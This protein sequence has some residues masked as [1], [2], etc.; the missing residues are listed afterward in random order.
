M[1]LTAEDAG[2]RHIVAVGE[3]VRVRLRETPTTGYLWRPEVDGEALELLGDSVDVADVPRGAPGW[4]VFRFRVRRGGPTA[5][6]LVQG[7]AWESSSTAEYRVD[8]DAEG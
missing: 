3:E 4:H 8:L 2:S 7:R 6:T 1:D 5:L